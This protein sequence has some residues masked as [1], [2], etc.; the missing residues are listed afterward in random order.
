M[1]RSSGD[2]LAVETVPKGPETT[3][4]DDDAFVGDTTTLLKG[5]TA[6]VDAGEIKLTLAVADAVELPEAVVTVLELDAEPSIFLDSILSVARLGSS[7]A[8]ST[9]VTESEIDRLAAAVEATLTKSEFVSTTV[10]ATGCSDVETEI[11][12]GGAVGPAMIMGPVEG[13]ITAFADATPIVSLIGAALADDSSAFSIATAADAA[14]PPPFFASATADAA[15]LAI[16][17]SDGATNVTAPAEAPLM[18]TVSSG[19][20]ETT[21]CVGEGVVW[22]ACVGVPGDTMVTG[23]EDDPSTNVVP[24]TG[25]RM[26]VPRTSS[27]FGGNR[28][29]GDSP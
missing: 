2:T 23:P 5:P 4:A 24:V 16:E 21:V 28:L 3:I 29:T 27:G 18:S 13:P 6:I 22:G 12:R 19:T 11:G 10:A 14:A 20:P 9:L 26:T 7:S 25:P 1:I 15:L 17:L 8:L